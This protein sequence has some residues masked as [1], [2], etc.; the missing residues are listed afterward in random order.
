M[1]ICIVQHVWTVMY[2]PT[3]YEEQYN[4][5]NSYLCTIH[6]ICLCVCVT[7][8]LMYMCNMW[9]F[10]SHIQPD[11]VRLF[12]CP[13]YLSFAEKKNWKL[14]A[15]CATIFFSYLPCAWAVLGP[16]HFIPL[17]ATLSFSLGHMFSGKTPVYFIAF[18]AFQLIKIK[19]DVVIEQCKFNILMLL[20]G[21]IVVIKGRSHLAKHFSMGL[22]GRIWCGVE[23]CIKMALWTSYSLLC[24]WTIS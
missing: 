16:Y 2:I 24:F 4:Y 18:H 6:L 15:I 1:F 14:H 10:I 13:V 3:Q 12:L 5:R 19:F 21:K 11:I 22:V 7:A 17:S 20:L 9:I 8:F 23:T